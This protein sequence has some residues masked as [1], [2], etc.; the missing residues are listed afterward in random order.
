MHTCLVTEPNDIVRR[1]IVFGWVSV[2]TVGKL[3]LRIVFHF[4][5]EHDPPVLQKPSMHSRNT[6]LTNNVERTRGWSS[7]SWWRT[8]GC[9]DS[10]SCAGPALTPITAMSSG[11]AAE[12]RRVSTR[13]PSFQLLL[14]SSLRTESSSSPEANLHRLY[15]RYLHHKSRQ[16]FLPR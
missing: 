11:L 13:P 15:C 8:R 7:G 2:L 1:W 6:C 16:L 10:A 5:E 9:N 14:E 4:I 12:L 3:D